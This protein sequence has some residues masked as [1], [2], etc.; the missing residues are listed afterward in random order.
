MAAPQR[1]LG[2]RDERVSTAPELAISGGRVSIG[3]LTYIA[4]R[5]A[6]VCWELAPGAMLSEETLATRLSVSRTPLREALEHLQRDNLIRRA[7]NGRLFVTELSAK[8]AIDLYAVRIALEDLIIV[9]A[10]RN[11]STAGL[12]ELKSCINNAA[13]GSADDISLDNDVQLRRNFHTTLATLS[14]NLI[15]PQLLHSLQIQSDRYRFSGLSTD[16]TRHVRALGEHMSIY[17]AINCGDMHTARVAMRTHLAN[18]CASALR[19]LDEFEA[20]AGEVTRLRDGP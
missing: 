12:Q 18:A 5:D 19:A 11:I 9:D 7:N 8:E 3:D 17:E 16:K 13:P 14:G 20:Y 1:T 15:S 6:I 4:L 10:I 2:V